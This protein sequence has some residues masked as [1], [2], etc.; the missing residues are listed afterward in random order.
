MLCMLFAVQR[1]VKEGLQM[2]QS[3]MQLYFKEHCAGIWGMQIPDDSIASKSHR[4]PIGFVKTA[5]VQGSKKLVA[6]GFREAV[7]LSHLREEQ[8]K[9]MPMEHWRR[10]IYVLV[11]NLISTACRLALASIVLEYQENDIGFL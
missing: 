9:E 8:R 3:A 1:K 11:R 10:K 2:S 4:W 6:E 7:L 5:S